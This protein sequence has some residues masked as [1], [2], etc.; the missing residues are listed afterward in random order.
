V[1]GR[2]GPAGPYMACKG[3]EVQSLSF[4]TAAA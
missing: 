1:I 3:S 4:A 2:D